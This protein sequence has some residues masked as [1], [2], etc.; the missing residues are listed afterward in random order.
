[1]HGKTFKSESQPCQYSGRTI[2]NFEISNKYLIM[3]SST[4]IRCFLQNYETSCRSVPTGQFLNTDTVMEGHPVRGTVR[5][6]RNGTNTSRQSTPQNEE[7]TQAQ[8]G[9]QSLP[10][11]LEQVRERPYNRIGIDELLNSS[12]ISTQEK[13]LPSGSSGVSIVTCNIDNCGR[14]YTSE[15]SLK[16][17]QSRHHATPTSLICRQCQT[18]YSSVANLNKHV[19]LIY[20][21]HAQLLLRTTL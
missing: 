11:R 7:S 15:E 5:S 20:Y 3:K 9:E 16:I 12:D 8:R 17:H 21:G 1:M 6:S 4:I 14:R 2:F 10:P 19:R 18:T 13:S